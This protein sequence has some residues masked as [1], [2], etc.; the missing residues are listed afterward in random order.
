MIFLKIIMALV[1]IIYPILIYFGISKFSINTVSGL[2]FV[3]GV[4]RFALVLI[5]EKDSQI[6][7]KLKQLITPAIIIMIAILSFL[8]SSHGWFQL[9][10]ILVSGSLLSLF[11]RSLFAEKTI[12]QYY[13]EKTKKKFTDFEIHY[14]RKVTKVWCLFFIINMIISFIT[15]QYFSLKIWTL[16]N[17]LISYLLMGSLFILEFAYRYFVILPKVKDT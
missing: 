11:Y 5:A 8:S 2:V 16:Y 13:A 14:I 15:W 10:P 9:Y 4:I 1:A 12:I 6:A 3:F 17:A 7:D